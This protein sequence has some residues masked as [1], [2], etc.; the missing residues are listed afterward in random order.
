M[1]TISATA[2][3]TATAQA[4]AHPKHQNP[5][6]LNANRP[7]PKPQSGLLSTFLWQ[8]YDYEGFRGFIFLLL[9]V[10]GY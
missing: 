1:A 3:M 4:T 5:S 9:R 8:D 7:K 6:I 10:L 2:T